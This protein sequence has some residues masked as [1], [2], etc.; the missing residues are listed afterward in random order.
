VSQAV[1][2]PVEN[3]IAVCE[4]PRENIARLLF[5]SGRSR[6]DDD[7]TL[8]IESNKRAFPGGR[9]ADRY[10]TTPLLR[11]VECLTVV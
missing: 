1:S 10:F 6:Q 5:V 9:G 11:V 4:F 3:P 8:P 7:R 2:G